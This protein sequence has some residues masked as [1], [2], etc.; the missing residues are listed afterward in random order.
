MNESPAWH[1]IESISGQLTMKKKMVLKLRGH[2]YIAVAKKSNSSEIPKK[3]DSFG[4]LGTFVW[5]DLLEQVW[6]TVNK[7]K[8]RATLRVEPDQSLHI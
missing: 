4:A 3:W 5:L 7:G 2:N 1:C 6:G 8:I